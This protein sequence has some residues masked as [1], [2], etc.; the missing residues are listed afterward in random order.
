MK[1][2]TGRSEMAPGVN[3]AKA[4]WP[5]NNYQ[6]CSMSSVKHQGNI[7]FFWWRLV[8]ERFKRLR[9]AIIAGDN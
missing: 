6:C 7:K 8:A 1:L 9:C 4:S 5:E 3:S 2:M